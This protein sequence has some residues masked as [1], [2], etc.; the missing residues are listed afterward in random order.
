[1]IHLTIRNLFA[2]KFRL[3][4]TSLA[5]VLG[6]GFMAGTFVLTDTLGSVFE[7][8]FSDTTKGVDA[9]V[10]APEPFKSSSRRITS[11]RPPVPDSLVSQVRAV[12]SVRG[13]QGNMLSYALVQN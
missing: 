6:V 1:M 5:V 4:L 13:A 12:D 7:T 9:I 10:R 8:L 3:F 2:R 11:T